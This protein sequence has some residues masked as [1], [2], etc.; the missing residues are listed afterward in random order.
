[1]LVCLLFPLL[2]TLFL[3]K[4]M[5]STDNLVNKKLQKCDLLSSTQIHTI[6]TSFWLKFL[7]FWLNHSKE[8]R[9]FNLFSID[10]NLL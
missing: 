7:P 8:T 6:L 1:M 3:V 4:N 10:N 2:L 5:N 9:E